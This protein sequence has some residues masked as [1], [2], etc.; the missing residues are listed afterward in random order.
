[1]RVLMQIK[2]EQHIDIASSLRFVAILSAVIPVEHYD[3]RPPELMIENLRCGQVDLN[4]L[5]FGSG[6]VNSLSCMHT[7]EHIG[8]G[9]Y[10][11]PLDVDGD[12]KAAEELSRVLAPDGN[13]LIVVPVGRSR[14]QFNAHRIYAYRQ[15]LDLFPSLSLKQYTLIP[16]SHATGDLIY[17]ASENL[18]DSQSHGCGC[19][20]FTKETS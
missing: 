5:P 3:Y 9:R 20:W 10:G 11:D 15:V 16:D 17:E 6:S 8:L 4:R 14:I 13:L 2:P 7:L 1:M 12:I 18:T 19:F